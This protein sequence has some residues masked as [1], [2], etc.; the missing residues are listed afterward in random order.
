MKQ[1]IK[2]LRA[3]KEENIVLKLTKDGQEKE[4]LI[5]FIGKAKEE[6]NLKTLVFHQALNTKSYTMI[7]GV[8]FDKAQANINGL[9][10][11]AKDA[12]FTRAFLEIK[13]LL[14][15]RH[16][17]AEAEPQ[18]EIEANEVKASHAA[19]MGR[20]DKEQLFYLMSRGLS[21]KKAEKIIV[22]GFLQPLK[23]KIWG[24]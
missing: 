11:I 17:L 4:L 19:T 24:S 10:K 20:I 22:A 15:G 13:I 1:T 7:R 21:R 23:D 2:Q 18:L 12:Q 9:I 8:L 6:F 16:C 14:V 3:G 5:S